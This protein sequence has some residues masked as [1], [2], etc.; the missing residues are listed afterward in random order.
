[1]A[2]TCM[3]VSPCVCH[4]DRRLSH[5]ATLAWWQLLLGARTGCYGDADACCLPHLTFPWSTE[6]QTRDV[7]VY[8]VPTSPFLQC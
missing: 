8:T 3:Y 1:L 5:R 7:G 6:C 4:V 2:T